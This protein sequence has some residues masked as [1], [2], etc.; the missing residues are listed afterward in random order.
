ME[1]PNFICLDQQVLVSFTFYSRV[2][3]PTLSRA[4][5]LA[6]RDIFF[7]DWFFFSFWTVHFCLF[8]PFFLIA[9]YFVRDSSFFYLGQNSLCGLISFLLFGTFI[10]L[11]PFSLYIYILFFLLH[12]LCEYGPTF[13][14]CVGCFCLARFLFTDLL[15]LFGPSFALDWP[16]LTLF[17]WLAPFTLGFIFWNG[18]DLLGICFFNF[19]LDFP[20]WALFFFLFFF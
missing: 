7:M 13:V 15:F 5:F 4:S 14:L 8:G 16:A 17:F 1:K 12:F 19:H 11:L 6:V 10:V 9:L 20:I 3:P 18:P 2:Y